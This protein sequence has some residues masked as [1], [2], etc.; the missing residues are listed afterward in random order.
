METYCVCADC[1]SGAFETPT[2]VHRVSLARQAALLNQEKSLEDLQR[3]LRTTEEVRA[4]RARTP[5]AAAPRD[6]ARDPPPT[7]GEVIDRSNE[8]KKVEDSPHTAV[9]N[10]GGGK[11]VLDSIS[12]H[13][14]ILDIRGSPPKFYDEAAPHTA[15]QW[16]D[17]VNLLRAEQDRV[18]PFQ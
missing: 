14:P 15:R 12:L 2:G 18:P 6:R 5:P 1:T 17:V 13:E 11:G 3:H 4:C 16:Q 10:Q 9:N 8:R 7:Q